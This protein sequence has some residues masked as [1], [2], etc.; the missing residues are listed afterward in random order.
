M[1]RIEE[2]TIRTVM[3][4]KPEEKRFRGIPREKW[5]DLVGEDLKVMEVQ[6]WREI[7]KDRE[8]GGM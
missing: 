1:R 7:V 6:E 2:E 8:D 4:W 5:L 3:E